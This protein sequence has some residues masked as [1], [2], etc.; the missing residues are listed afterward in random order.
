MPA[1]P[2]VRR[3]APAEQAKKS[4]APRPA[5]SKPAKPAPAPAVPKERQRGVRQGDLSATQPR[6]PAPAASDFVRPNP[7][8]G[9]VVMDATARLL[10]PRTTR[11]YAQPSAPEGHNRQEEPAR[12]S[13]SSKHRRHKHSGARSQGAPQ[14]APAP[15]LPRPPKASGAPAPAPKGHRP[16]RPPRRTFPQERPQRGQR[17]STETPGSLM[18][19]YYLS[20]D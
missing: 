11:L 17:D 13:G 2:L 20:D 3:N 5:Q 16:S 7:M 12:T 9:D 8:D 10:A 15:E 18:K 19:P 1:P 14:E 6:R 4:A